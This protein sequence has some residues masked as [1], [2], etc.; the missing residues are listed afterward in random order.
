MMMLQVLVY[1]NWKG[2]VAMRAILMVKLMRISLI[3]EQEK[4]EELD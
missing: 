4:D 2:Y 1:T 3:K